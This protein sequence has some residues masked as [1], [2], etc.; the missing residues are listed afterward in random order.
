M[1]EAGRLPKGY[2]FGNI[3]AALKNKIVYINKK[4]GADVLAHEIG[5]QLGY[6]KFDQKLDKLD[7]AEHHNNTVSLGTGLMGF[8]AG[9]KREKDKKEGTAFK[10]DLRHAALLGGSALLVAPSL[11]KEGGATK[12]AFKLLK[13]AGATKEQLKNARKSLGSGYT[14]HALY[15][16]R[17]AI[18]SEVGYQSGRIAGKLSGDDREN[19]G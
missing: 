1:H 14:S 6:G 4:D 19:N 8:A 16:L 9:Y 13:D 10:H 12:R 2:K 17:P 5:H 15:A 11:I 7:I 3:D 18:S